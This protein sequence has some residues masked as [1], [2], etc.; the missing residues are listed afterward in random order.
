MPL[1]KGILPFW[2]SHLD[3]QPMKSLL[4]YGRIF[5]VGLGLLLSASQEAR[6][7]VSVAATTSFDD[8][9]I[10]P[11]SGTVSYISALQI[12]AFAQAGAN[13]QFSS[14][15][16]SIANATDVPVLGGLATGS[17]IASLGPV[18]GT[19]TSTAMI[20][21]ATAGFDTATGQ[22]SASGIF[23]IQGV[24]G[25]VS[26]TL[27]AVA[28]G[29]LN[30][31]ADAYGVY[32]QGESIFTLSIDGTPDLFT[33]TLMSV[34]PN[35]T[36]GDTFSDSL[37]DTVTLMANTPYW[38]F[39]QADSEAL[40]V[41]SAIA[42]PDSFTGPE[43]IGCLMT[44]VLLLVWFRR[45]QELNTTNRLFLAL[46]GGALAGATMP[47]HATY[48]GSD[49]PDVCLTCGA[50][51]TRIPAGA[52]NTSLTEGNVRADYLAVRVRSSFGTTMPFGLSYNSYNA[53]GSKAQLDTGVGF[54]WTHTYNAVLFQ[55][56]GQMFR[57]GP[58]GRVVQ[59][60]MSYTGTGGNYVSD[61]G[62]FETLTLQSD[63]TYYVT[64][65]NQS[66]WQ[67][68]TVP[69]TTLLIEGP[70]Y[71]LLQM[72]D[73]NQN[74][75]TL[76]Y[77]SGGQLIT[78]TDTYGRTLQFTYDTHNHL[79]TI[80]DP[81]GR[82][83]QLQYDPQY[84]MPTQITDPLGNITQYT[85]NAEY[86]M[87]RQVDA[88][89][90]IFFYTYK[91]LRPFMTTDGSGQPWFSLTNPTNWS[92]NTTN[93]AFTL[94]RNYYPGTT[95]STDG[96]GHV[97]QYTY[98][99]NGYILQTTAP[100][101]TT[102]RYT[103]DSSTLMLATVTDANNNE[104]KYQYDAAGNRIETIDALGNITTYTYEPVFNMMTSMTDPNGRTTTF[105][106][107]AHGNR[108]STTDALTQV[109]SW[110]YD[111]HGNVLTS[112]DK[113]DYTTQ[114]IYDGNGDLIETIDPLSDTTK[115]TYDTVGN[116]LTKTDANG[117]ETVY[118]YDLDDRL[119]Q[120]VDPHGYINTT[121]YDGDGDVIL[122]TDGNR[123]TTTN[124]Y[125][126]RDRLVATT[127][128]LDGVVITAYDPNDNIIT[129]TD[130]N[131]HTTTYAYDTLNRQIT[132]TDPLGGVT[133]TAYDP[134]GNVVSTTDPDG[135]T[136]S[137]NYDA[138]NRVIL[139]TDPLSY[140]TT[141]E[142]ANTAGPPCCGA[143]AGSALVTGII[144]GNGKIT[145][146]HY[147]ELNRCIQEVHK[148]GSVTD[149]NTL[150]DA[151]TTT[152]YDADNDKIAVT[153]P[154]TNTTTTTYDAL[155]RQIST[156]DAAGDVSTTTYDAVG[157]VIQTVNP[158]GD[159]TSIVYDTDNRQI[160]ITDSVGLVRTNE[161]DADGDVIAVA[162]G[163]GYITMNMYDANDRQIETI[164]PLGKM[165]LTTY[166]PV[167]NELS[168]TDRNGQ[169]TTYTYD[170]DNRETNTVDAAGRVTVETYDPDGNIVS[171]TDPLKNATTYTYDADNRQIEETDA[172]G[173]TVTYT[174]D[175]T[176]H[177]ISRLDQDGQ[178][179]SYELNDFYYLTNREY[180]VG[181]SDLFKYDVGGRVLEAS[182]GDWTNRFTYDG[183][184]RVL[185]SEQYGQTVDY[186]YVIPSGIRDV[187]Y[188]GGVTVTESYDLRS[189]LVE[190]NDGGSPAITQYTY[191]LDNN[192]LSRMNRNGTASDYTYDA[193]DRTTQLTHNLGPTLITGFGYAYDNEGNR[194]YQSNQ[195]ASSLSET[196]IYDSVYRLTDFDV[197]T[198][199]GGVITSP[200]TAEQYT[201]DADDNWSS[202]KS[203]TVTQTRTHNDVNEILTISGNPSPTYDNNGNLL[204][205][206]TYS[207]A[208]DP[209]NRV[210]R[211]TQ[212]SDS[213]I[214][215]QYAYDAFGRRITSLAD[216]ALTP[217]TNFYIYDGKRI[218]EE[219]NAA[220]NIQSTFTYGGYVDE[221]LTMTNGGGVYYYHPNSLYSIEA[222]TDS[223]G[224]P[225]ERYIYDAYG[226]PRVL[227]GSY[228]PEPLNAWGTPHSG[229]NNIY[230]F[231][232]RQ[233]DEERGLYFY[234]ARYYHP[235]LGRFVERDP[236]SPESAVINLYDYV[237][238]NPVN[239]L[240]PTGRQGAAKEVEQA[241]TIQN[242]AAPTPARCGGVDWVIRW[243]LAKDTKKGGAVMQE[244]TVTWNIKDCQ[245][246]KIFTDRVPFR[247]SGALSVT[248]PLH[249]WEIWFLQKNTRAPRPP[250]D[251]YRLLTH[252]CTQGDATIV[253]QASYFD[254][255]TLPKDRASGWA[256]S[257]PQTGAGI[258]WSTTV[259]PTTKKPFDAGGTAVLD[260]NLAVNWN[261]CPD[262]KFPAIPVYRKTQIVSYTPEARR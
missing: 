219:Q 90:R 124:V 92:V 196:Y 70:V 17:G 1:A 184:D 123:Y 170:A 260:H 26:V 118:T 241:L 234:R 53:D 165:T 33:D 89:G 97:W 132:S 62:Y 191:D 253:G 13:A 130:E 127:N 247:T 54:G 80:T 4:S 40:V 87:T 166:D 116:R 71:R 107:D 189:R 57:L 104:T 103:Y 108:I 66:W 162:D 101:S 186:S 238:S 49:A 112:T 76:A 137:Y 78:A 174:Y 134:V 115:Y 255:V 12:S 177:V 73:R 152:T 239:N 148:S 50:Q 81:L 193:D 23:E 96:D 209:E 228:N 52:I 56:R 6:A 86:Q 158:R 7:N 182:R 167:G 248:N 142:Y 176:G 64:N 139:V 252:G 173:R 147:D 128:A 138:L 195:T 154:N 188:P 262:P 39:E 242:S 106:Y 35:Q 208:Y 74:T 46:L 187:T 213:A 155:D 220:S 175:G 121:T 100:D 216:P 212:D 159:V 122:T 151:V 75:T 206:G 51:P 98:D 250:T 231:T 207:Y 59:Y 214:V 135:Y 153:D 194:L 25:P 27:S 38:I 254:D 249:Y 211:I 85:Y 237:D 156:T 68:G 24:T 55:Q 41:N 102:T 144:D 243:Q 72:G 94:R 145:Y 19:G 131:G 163:D 16:P 21:G 222:L 48:I 45:R 178:T 82:A 210:V 221:P 37:T 183:A 157:N 171:F 11:S 3:E 88:D 58:D 169:T 136:T 223:T 168:S 149:V 15:T 109:E 197:G 150:S 133:A 111:S 28:T 31:F 2:W 69:G 14:L 244:I 203:N 20:S 198:L 164:D 240:D 10:D 95:S 205:D 79:S 18:T 251:T 129:H 91:S 146:Y 61:T 114:Y 36:Q 47:A 117:H 261:C 226:E 93:L 199:S 232:G 161:Y 60:F 9:S 63:G 202:F 32:G 256:T 29:S 42:I 246:N 84:R 65:K 125:D 190:V 225:V 99:T 44:S 5:V 172:N 119:I 192:V 180:S 141:Y 245:G 218:L 217:S 201:Y 120:T 105:T 235:T 257:N 77:N 83:T 43:T 34:G 215:G 259:D 113:R 67:F 185:T 181:P 110:T 8:V 224:T 126:L 258:L 229:V 200:S 227:D 143:T 233:L 236:A 22:A 204:D 160:Q 230:L 179:T 30:L 140:T